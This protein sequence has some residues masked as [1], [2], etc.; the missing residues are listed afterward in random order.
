M[1]VLGIVVAI[2]VAAFASSAFAQNGRYSREF[3]RRT[4]LQFLR[5]GVKQKILYGVLPLNMREATRRE[6]RGRRRHRLNQEAADTN[7]R[8]K[9][10]LTALAG[11]LKVDALA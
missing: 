3:L 4:L 6:C 1:R 7:R 2:P 8:E 9:P 11:K 10:T 5:N